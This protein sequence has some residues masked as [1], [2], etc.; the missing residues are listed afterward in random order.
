MAGDIDQVGKE[1]RVI[2]PS[3]LHK[4]EGRPKGRPKGGKKLWIIK[5]HNNNNNR[6]W[7]NSK[8]IWDQKYSMDLVNVQ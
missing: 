2:R 4:L 8:Y 6:I 1:M 5:G 7:K 3:S